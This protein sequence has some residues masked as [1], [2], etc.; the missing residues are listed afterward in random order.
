MAAP[1]AFARGGVVDG[2]FVVTHITDPL[3]GSSDTNAFDELRGHSIRFVISFDRIDREA[4]ASLADGGQR[5]ILTTNPARVHFL[6][7]PTGYLQ[8]VIAPTLNCALQITLRENAS[9]ITVLES[10]DIAEAQAPQYFGFKGAGPAEVSRDGRA[11]GTQAVGLDTDTMVLQ[12]FGS[13]LGMT[14]LATGSL[15]YSLFENVVVGVEPRAF[16]EIKAL[17]RTLE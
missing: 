4:S 3:A 2:T 8:E 1:L 7:D 14:D 9:G 11:P 15:R 17:Y 10:F 6:G 12:R 5:R 16:G 13:T